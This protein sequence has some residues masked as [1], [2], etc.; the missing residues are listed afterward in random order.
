MAPRALFLDRD[1]VINIDYIDVYKIENFV[2]VDGIFD[3]CRKAQDLGYLNIVITNQSGIAR[4]VFTREAVDMLHAYMIEEFQK[5]SIAITDIYICASHDNAHEDR[6]PNPGLLL[7]AQKKYQINMAA[8]I[9]LGDKERDV[10]AGINAGCG[11]NIL[12]TKTAV[13]T[14]ATTT[15]SNIRDILPLLLPNK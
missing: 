5:R 9:M 4:G 6:K 7:K 1:G 12:L 8:S 14:N 2:F 11:Q 13:T 3:V 15:I 10:L